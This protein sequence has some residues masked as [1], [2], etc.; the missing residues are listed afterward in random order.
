MS[1]ME[2][3][4]ELGIDAKDGLARCMNKEDFYLKMLK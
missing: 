2:T 1:I 3:L 4:K